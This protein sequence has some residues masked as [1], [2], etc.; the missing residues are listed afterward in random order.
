MPWVA[1]NG[2]QYNLCLLDTNIIS[3]IVKNKR[4]ELRGFLDEFPP[5]THIICI[6]I[7]S[8]IELRRNSEVFEKF[9]DVFSVIPFFILKPFYQMFENERDLYDAI[10]F[11]QPI[12]TAITMANQDP[13]L[14]LRN[15]IQ[16]LFTN[17][18]II[19]V[20]KGWRTDESSVLNN[21]ISQIDNFKPSSDVANAGDAD[22]YV[23]EASLQTIMRLDIDWAKKKVEAEEFIDTRKFPSVI[24]MLYSQYYRLYD[25][26]WKARP[27]EITDISIIGVAPYV[28]VVITEFF[29]AE[30]LKKIKSRVNGMSNLRIATL[31]DIRQ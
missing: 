2:T 29:Q 28:D 20:E 27:Q 30:I 17:E 9:L 3:E 6:T 23:E 15:L 16:E 25:P 31:R 22:R 18:E 19:K 21:W 11:P 14:H 10:E 5:A 24:A 1:E 12:L 4:G 13:R 26:Y 7:Y 8:L